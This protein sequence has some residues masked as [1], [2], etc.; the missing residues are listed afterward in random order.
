MMAPSIR[1]AEDF[2]GTAGGIIVGIPMILLNGSFFGQS[3]FLT[4]FSNKNFCGHIVSVLTYYGSMICM[5]RYH[6]FIIL[7][8]SP[9]VLNLPVIQS[10]WLIIKSFSFESRHL[11]SVLPK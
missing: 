1:K 5:I 10:F 7:H 4:V 2:A 9:Y 6:D 11:L 3:G 8:I